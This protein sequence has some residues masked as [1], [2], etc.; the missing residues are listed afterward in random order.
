MAAE[1]RARSLARRAVQCEDLIGAA[2]R[3]LRARLGTPTERLDD[4]EPVPNEDWIWTLGVGDEGQS[5]S[6]ATLFVE[7]YRGRAVY[8]E[9]PGS[10]PNAGHLKRGTPAG[11]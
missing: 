9:A 11:R 3:E 10:Q 6:D 8:A 7:L 4:G 1:R 5:G 2:P